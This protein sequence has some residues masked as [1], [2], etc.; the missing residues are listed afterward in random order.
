MPLE[1]NRMRSLVTSMPSTTT[2][3]V[4]SSETPKIG[5]PGTVTLTGKCT[6]TE[7]VP[8]GARLTPSIVNSY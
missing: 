6:V 1:L 5:A 2:V 3:R 8:G 7:E 4:S